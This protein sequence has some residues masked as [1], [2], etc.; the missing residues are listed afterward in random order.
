MLA[1]KKHFLLL[2]V[3]VGGNCPGPPN[4]STVDGSSVGMEVDYVG[5]WNSI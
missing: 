3:A 5:V 4:N 1:H 2:N